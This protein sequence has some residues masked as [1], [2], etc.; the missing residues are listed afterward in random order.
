MIQENFSEKELRK[1][2]INQPELNFF[3]NNTVKTAKY[4]LFTF[5]P[6]A[7]FY[8]FN[9]YFNVFFL[10]TAIILSIKDISPMDPAV[11]IFPFLFVL[12]VS[13]VREAIEDYVLFIKIIISIFVFL[14]YNLF[15]FAII[16]L[17]FKS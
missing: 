3:C 17:F 5:F 1:I 12:S 11:A 2:Y 6:L 14:V 4:N 10:M 13:I 16:I 8:Q 9:N 15:I 7:V